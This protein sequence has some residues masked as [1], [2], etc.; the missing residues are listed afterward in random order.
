[1]AS[2]VT[3]LK[4]RGRGQSA[5]GREETQALTHRSLFLSPKNKECTR[6]RGKRETS[7][8]ETGR[9]R[10]TKCAAQIT[11]T[12][13]DKNAV[14]RVGQQ[15]RAK[16]EAG[17]TT[18]KKSPDADSDDYLLVSPWSLAAAPGGRQRPEGQ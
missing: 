5:K 1:M 11:A 7:K 3:L 8:S 6:A 13:L 16:E 15:L 10:R 14:C 18:N 9:G 2:L 17:E 4:G 12:Q